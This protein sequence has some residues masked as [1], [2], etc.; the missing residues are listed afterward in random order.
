MNQ[1]HSPINDSELETDEA[2]R[3][4]GPTE[5]IEPPVEFP[6][7]INA[8]AANRNVI[9]FQS[10]TPLDPDDQRLSVVD[11]L[12]DKAALLEAK[13][14]VRNQLELRL[15]N[16]LAAEQ[17]AR[18][19]VEAALRQRDDFL[20]IAAHGLRT[21]ITVLS[22]H[23]QRLLRQYQRSRT[24]DPEELVAALETIAHHSEKM[25]R[26]IDEILD[27][28]RIQSGT[29]TLKAQL[30]DLSALVRRAVADIERGGSDVQIHAS[31]PETLEA[32]VDP[33]RIELVL[34]NLLENAI[35]HSPHGIPVEVDLRRLDDERIELSVRD[36]GQGIP[37][38]RREQ[39]FERFFQAHS[40]GFNS[41]LGLGLH[42]CGQIMTLHGGTIRAEF[43][44]DGGSR[45]VAS[46]CSTTATESV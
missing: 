17:H 14:A 15:Q 43:P 44:S 11:D 32:V 33:G 9:P 4:D 35:K 25:S 46:L 31:L 37:E 34:T 18:E 22:G 23:T 45:F 7:G 8:Q 19:E 39:L 21:P 36:F 29:I 12:H 3:K 38:E 42:L 30:I 20:A 27:T 1:Q 13:I 24:I 28:T 41:G 26:L 10:V 2:L 6:V 5:G 16:A 40:P